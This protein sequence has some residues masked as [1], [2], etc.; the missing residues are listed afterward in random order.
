MAVGS[1]VHLVLDHGKKFF[2]RLHIWIII[3]AGGINIQHL[4]P[5]NLFRGPDIPDAGQKLIKVVAAVGLFKALVIQ[6]EFFRLLQRS[7][8][9]SA[10]VDPL[11]FL[12]PSLPPRNMT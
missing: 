9:L 1:P 11:F 3:N 8:N 2:R 5:K 10:V 4:A 7:G 6:G 12:T